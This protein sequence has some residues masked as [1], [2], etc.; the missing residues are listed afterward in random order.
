MMTNEEKQDDH[1]NYV[2]K[3][4]L[5][6]PIHTT[7]EHLIFSLHHLGLKFQTKVR[8]T[9]YSETSSSRRSLIK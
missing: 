2:T 1:Q 8:Y 7:Y 9:G 3:I 4:T 6:S 5:L